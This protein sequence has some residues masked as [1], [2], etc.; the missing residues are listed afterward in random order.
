MDDGGGDYGDDGR[1]DSDDNDAR[2][3]LV[4]TRGA[5]RGDLGAQKGSGGATAP[6]PY[7]RFRCQKGL[8]TTRNC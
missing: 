3:Y 5:H 4:D 1:D 8:M 6:R 7:L 2:Y